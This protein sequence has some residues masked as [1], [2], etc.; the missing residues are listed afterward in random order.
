MTIEELLIENQE[1]LRRMKNEDWD[2]EKFI[3]ELKGEKNN[4]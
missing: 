4:E 1:I 2:T 3:S